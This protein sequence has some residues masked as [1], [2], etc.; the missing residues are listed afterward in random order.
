MP[1]RSAPSPQ[2]REGLLSLLSRAAGQ[3][4]ISA[5]SFCN[6]LGL[7][8]KKLVNHDGEQ[9]QQ[10]ADILGLDAKTL[11]EVRSWTMQ[12]LLGVQV[13]FRGEAYG[14]RALMNPVVRGC[15]SCLREDVATDRAPPQAQMVMRGHWQLKYVE[16]CHRHGQPLVPIWQVSP[17]LERHDF[18]TNFSRL[19]TGILKGD[20]PAEEQAITTYDNWLDGRLSGARDTG[21]ILERDIDSAATFCNLLGVEMI[22]AFPDMETAI[23]PARA[24][25]FDIVNQGNE[26]ISRALKELSISASGPQDGMRQAFGRLYQWLAHDSAQNQRCNIYRD[27]VRD[28]ILD[29]WEVPSGEII[30]GTPVQKRRWHSIQSASIQTGKSVTVTRQILEHAGVIK[31]DDARPH[32]R[33]IFDAAQAEPTLKWCARLVRAKEMAEHLGASSGQFETLARENL[34][35]PALPISISKF[36]WDKRDADQ[37][38]KK[39]TV[40]AKRVVDD[41]SWVSFPIAAGRAHVSLYDASKAVKDGRI[42]VVLLQDLRGYA[43]IHVQQAEMNLLTSGRPS[44]PT[45]AEFGMEV[46]LQKNGTMNALV[47]AGHVQATRMFSPATRRMGLYM[48]DED[49]EAF[50]AIFTTLKLLSSSLDIDPR[51]L[52][53][54]LRWA[55]INQFRIEEREFDRVYRIGDIHDS[56]FKV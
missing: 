4:E 54:K 2:P 52:R 30:L 35:K 38:L 56:D 11:R 16:I 39:L 10:V 8:F 9:V 27:L 34:I 45:L 7:S 47:E 51:D 41:G 21:W 20:K 25:G 22:R 32:K 15:L 46:G 43:G 37:F 3:R 5:R 29:S 26:A 40:N 50:H 23:K 44:A 19:S 28:V 17:L 13:Q 24:I 18:A 53:R 55:G 33:L 14:S 12:P 6:E 1:L 36:Q 48:T 31:R 42:D 49:Q